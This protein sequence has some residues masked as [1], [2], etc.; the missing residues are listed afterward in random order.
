MAC[1]SGASSGTVRLVTSADAVAVDDCVLVN[2][3]AHVV[4]AR[5]EDDAVCEVDQVGSSSVLV[6]GKAAGATTVDVD[7]DHGSGKVNVSFAAPQTD[8]LHPSMT[9]TDDACPTRRAQMR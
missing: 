5:C 6:R 3:S 4:G 1:A 2:A 7:Y 8:V 9:N